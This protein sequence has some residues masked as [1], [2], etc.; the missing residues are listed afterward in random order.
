LTDKNDV[1]LEI[2]GYSKLLEENERAKIIL[3]EFS[4]SI[5]ALGSIRKDAD[6]IAKV[7]SLPTDVLY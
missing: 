4:K 6:I 1:V 5:S 3:E 2:K 7:H